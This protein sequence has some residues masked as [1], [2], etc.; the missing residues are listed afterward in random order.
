MWSERM[1]HATIQGYDVIDPLNPFR[2]AHL[3]Y[4]G[5]RRAMSDLGLA[6]R[7]FCLDEREES[8]RTNKGRGAA[9]IRSINS[10]WR[11][12]ILR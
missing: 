1:A 9:S 7:V 12:A 11:L 5:Y 2:A 3:R 6:E 10:P 4:E 8:L